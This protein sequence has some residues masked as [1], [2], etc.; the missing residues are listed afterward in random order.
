MTS[1]REPVFQQWHDC[2]HAL[3]LEIIRV[4]DAPA[5]F[6]AVSEG[7]IVPA[8]FLVQV[9]A[10]KEVDSDVAL[11][12][13]QRELGPLAE[14]LHRGAADRA[15][16]PIMIAVTPMV[17]K[18]D[19]EAISALIGSG[20]KRW[21]PNPQEAVYAEQ[22]LEAVDESADTV[23]HL[24]LVRELPAVLDWHCAEAAGHA[25]VLVPEVMIVPDAEG[26]SGAW[27]W[28]YLR[29]PDVYVHSAA[30][31]TARRRSVN[32][33]LTYDAVTA[34]LQQAAP[35]ALRAFDAAAALEAA[36]STFG[37][38]IVA[39]ADVLTRLREVAYTN[40]EGKPD[41]RFGAQSRDWEAF[42]ADKS[43]WLGRLKAAGVTDP[44]RIRGAVFVPLDTTLLPAFAPPLVP[45]AWSDVHLLA[46]AVVRRVHESPRLRASVIVLC[47]KTLGLTHIPAVSAVDF[48]TGTT[49]AFGDVA[50]FLKE[51]DGVTVVGGDLYH[52]QPRPTARGTAGDDDSLAQWLLQSTTDAS[53]ECLN[54]LA[55]LLWKHFDA[56]KFAGAV[57]PYAS[58][59]Q[60][61]SEAPVLGSTSSLGYMR[62]QL[63]CDY[64]LKDGIGIVNRVAVQKLIVALNYCIQHGLLE[65]PGRYAGIDYMAIE[66]ASFEQLLSLVSSSDRDV[67][68][69]YRVYGGLEVA[70]NAVSASMGG[71]SRAGRVDPTDQAALGS[72][73]SQASYGGIM[74]AYRNGQFKSSGH[75]LSSLYN[76][77][78]R[79]RRQREAATA[80]AGPG[81]PVAMGGGPRRAPRETYPVSAS[82][83]DALLKAANAASSA[84]NH[85]VTIHQPATQALTAQY[86]DRLDISAQGQYMFGELSKE[87]VQPGGAREYRTGAVSARFGSPVMA[88][89]FA[90][91]RYESDVPRRKQKKGKAPTV[92][93][94]FSALARVASVVGCHPCVADAVGVLA[95]PQQLWS[96]VV[97]AD[98]VYDAQ[99]QKLEKLLK[100]ST[101][102]YASCMVGADKAAAQVERDV[103]EGVRPR[104]GDVFQAVLAQQ[105]PRVPLKKFMNAHKYLSG[106]A[107]T[108]YIRCRTAEQQQLAEFLR[109]KHV[110]VVGKPKCPYTDTVKHLFKE[111]GVAIEYSEA[112]DGED[113]RALSAA[114]P[115]HFTTF[116]AVVVE[117][118]FIG[119]S[120]ETSTWLQ[121]QQEAVGQAFFQELMRGILADADTDDADA[122]ESE[123]DEGEASEDDGEGE[124][125]EDDGEGE[126]SE[127]EVDE[128]GSEDDGDGDGYGSDEDDDGQ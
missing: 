48:Q 99:N 112:K 28:R 24:N 105:Y 54:R 36:K 8:W 89:R 124:A 79:N 37:A 128:G 80:A 59:L 106:L 121:K 94:D 114:V 103:K 14:R 49:Y 12:L 77:Y 65:R 66:D 56:D 39:E 108:L 126:A 5:L 41:M 87:L 15:S 100:Y 75:F 34:V 30:V 107:Q 98:I 115:A 102:L 73:V 61:V 68:A 35:A 45:G 71:Q 43:A 119:G 82:E 74:R 91:S 60:V 51:V 58:E 50:L 46:D 86:L 3:D 125:D 20:V 118:V 25:D 117:G 69:V 1:A 127:G 44:E 47:S 9:E 33:L 76:E 29:R 83:V 109:G 17:T 11:S 96:N 85:S 2:V 120:T 42:E 13:L 7:R 64:A 19:R 72:N 110:H 22:K 88:L 18:A 116:P 93:F 57:A 70:R 104:P 32:T 38:T 111:L 122:D 4:Q 31:D 27:H 113:V 123:A 97:R 84:V 10:G 81:R 23:L 92:T 26:Q 78:D 62:L 6:R 21:L 63:A 95:P 90:V 101:S 53:W 67:V 16:P 40:A 55:G 52:E